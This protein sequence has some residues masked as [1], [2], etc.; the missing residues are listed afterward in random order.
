MAEQARCKCG[1]LHPVQNLQNPAVQPAGVAASPDQA[2][3]LQAKDSKIASLKI[4][5]DRAQKEKAA[6]EG[7]VANLRRR[8]DRYE[9]NEKHA[10]AVEANNA[11]LRDELDVS[12]R[13]ID[14][15]NHLLAKE[16]ADHT[17]RLM[18]LTIEN[19]RLREELGHKERAI[20]AMQKTTPPTTPRDTKQQQSRSAPSN[21]QLTT[22]GASGRAQ[23]EENTGATPAIKHTN[24][25]PVPILVQHGPTPTAST[26]SSDAAGSH[27]TA[28]HRSGN[29]HPSSHHYNDHG[30]FGEPKPS[31][32]ND[33]DHFTTESVNTSTTSSPRV[34]QHRT[35]RR[36]MTSI[37]EPE[38]RP[39]RLERAL[40]ASGRQKVR[41]PEE[42]VPAI[43][44]EQR[45]LKRRSS[46]K[47][48]KRSGSNLSRRDSIRSTSSSRHGSTVDSK[49][50]PSSKPKA[51]PALA[52]PTTTMQRKPSASPQPKRA[53][54][55]SPQVQQQQR[56][57]SM[58]PGTR[59]RYAAVKPRYLDSY[60]SPSRPTPASGSS[61]LQVPSN[62]Y[63][64][65][66]SVGSAKS[67][68]SVEEELEDV[69][70]DRDVLYDREYYLRRQLETW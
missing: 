34:V 18:A 43:L 6:A 37:T 61:Y 23:S 62:D 49:V 30:L 63:S 25:Q 44:E 50:Q 69:R 22:L 45:E 40:V 39:F 20:N 28:P 52:I 67:A 17:Q 58:S 59:T 47:R 54:S 60:G 41:Y 29:H 7:D 4:E 14:E 56:N 68:R 65:G 64:R 33:S 55:K 21:S 9:G 10:D 13:R 12:D 3:A 42:Y 51:V 8:L 70:R 36:S 35:E 31:P 27:T 15:L 38:S 2:A 5:L 46:S 53:A 11:R 26:P 24:V 1:Y 48:L 19:T 16:R 32:S 66:A 57:K